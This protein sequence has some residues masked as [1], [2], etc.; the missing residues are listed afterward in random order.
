MRGKQFLREILGI[1][2]GTTIAA[3]ALN[4]FLVPN[5]LAAGGI[6]GLGIIFYHTFGIPVGL[7]IVVGNLPLLLLALR[8]LGLRFLAHTVAG[9]LLISV[10]VEVLAFLPVATTD[11]LLAA[12][13]GG[14]IMGI[15][16]GIVFRANG[17]TGGTALAAQLLHHIFGITSGQGIIISDIL[18]VGAAGVIFGAEVGLYAA[19]ALFVGSWVIDLIQEG[20]SLAKAA[21]IISNKDEE[22]TKRIFLDMDRGV[23]RV[24]ALG[25]YTEERRGIILCVF[26]RK[27]TSRLKRL[28]Y[29]IDPGAFVIVGSASEVLGEGFRRVGQ[30]P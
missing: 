23:T 21:V 12:V 13:Y 19:I 8:F 27:Q 29:E 17:S 24:E 26:G 2:I 16:I 30:A 4:M 14:L 9:I 10:M 11:I 22:I 7:T 1:F 3:A 15:G 5:M 20:F 25:G 6:S 18:I 28:V